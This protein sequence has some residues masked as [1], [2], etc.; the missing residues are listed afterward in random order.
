MPEPSRKPK[1]VKWR[2]EGADENLSTEPEPRIDIEPER[3]S[4]NNSNDD[5]LKADKP[6]HW[7]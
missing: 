4:N 6:P 2:P 7:G 5:R 1:R 3:P